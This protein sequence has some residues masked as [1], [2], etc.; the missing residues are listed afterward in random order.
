MKK[1]FWKQDWFTGVVISCL[2]FIAAGTGLLRAVAPPLFNAVKQG[3]DNSA[4]DR[5]AMLTFTIPAWPETV[6]SIV[7][8]SVVLYL[9][10]VL[11]RLNTI[12]AAVISFVLFAL[13]LGSNQFFMLGQGLWI[14]LLYPAMLLVCGH[15][16]LS[17]KRLL[18]IGQSHATTLEHNRSQALACQQQGRLDLAL[19]KFRQ[20]P[21]DDTIMRPLYGPGAVI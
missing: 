2:F 5:G 1:G 16:L 4:G 17:T 6:E 21:L 13:L 7:L 12:L 18:S 10:W 20:C 3:L 11:P 9:I 19:E 8:V 14:A 15:L